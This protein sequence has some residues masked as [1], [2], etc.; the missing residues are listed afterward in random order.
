MDELDQISGEIVS[1]YGGSTATGKPPVHFCVLHDAFM[2]WDT[3]IREESSDKIESCVAPYAGDLVRLYFKHVHPV[4]SVLSK[5]RFLRAFKYEKLSLPAS[6]RGVV[7]GLAAVFWDQDD[8]LKSVPRPFEQYQLFHAAQA[9]LERELDAPNMWKL[10]ACLLMLHEQ[11]ASNHTFQTPRTWTLSAQAVAC[12]QMIG[13]HRD[14]TDWNLEPWEKAL[15]KKLW[16]ATYMT[17]A[18]A[19]VSHG[20][21]PHIYPQSYTTTNASIDDLRMDEDVPDDLLD[22]VEPQDSYFNVSTAARF[23]EN[24]QLTQIL[25]NLLDTSFSDRSYQIGRTDPLELEGRLG[26]LLRELEDWRSLI[27]A[28]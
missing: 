9:S 21:P 27:R 25:H 16:W 12:A 2:P 5:T 3:A 28:V 13:L 19:S 23:V 20:N 26:R 18:W 6:L 22:L 24:V 11:P 14:P 8:T 4:Y 17:D 7:Y 15:R 1:V 10:Q